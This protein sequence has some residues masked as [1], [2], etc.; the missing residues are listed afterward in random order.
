MCVLLSELE[1][2]PWLLLV[3]LLSPLTLLNRCRNHRSVMTSLV[4]RGPTQ[5][6]MPDDVGGGNGSLRASYP[7][8]KDG[9][10]RVGFPSL[11]AEAAAGRRNQPLASILRPLVPPASYYVQRQFQVIGRALLCIASHADGPWVL[12][13]DSR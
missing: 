6:K 2:L 5:M 4:G 3:A 1:L 13:E 12:F 11:E 7:P 10:D 9:A 8:Q